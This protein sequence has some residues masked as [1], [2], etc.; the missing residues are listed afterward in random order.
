MRRGWATPNHYF[1]SQYTFGI[2]MCPMDVIFS[3]MAPPFTIIPKEKILIRLFLLSGS[4]Q[5][6]TGWHLEKNIERRGW[7][8]ALWIVLVITEFLLCKIAER[9]H[10]STLL[11][12]IATAAHHLHKP[13]SLVH[14][15]TWGS[16]GLRGSS[17]YM[18]AIILYLI[19]M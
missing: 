8:N 14:S 1:S 3:I 9:K 4:N 2:S 6:E 7:L 5:T 12:S 15:H 17:V 13:L 16:A 11:T 18:Q 10:F 19:Y